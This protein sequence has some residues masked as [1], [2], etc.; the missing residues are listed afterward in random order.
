ML[1]NNTL[2][3][4]VTAHSTVIGELYECICG[5][6]HGLLSHLYEDVPAIVL[7]NPSQDGIVVRHYGQYVGSCGE[8]TRDGDVE[9]GLDYVELLVH[10]R[11]VFVPDARKDTN[12]VL[13]RASLVY[14][15][16][17]DRTR[18]FSGIFKSL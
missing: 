2:M 6:I 9:R 7:G 11:V 17:S 3:R 8:G 1:E 10:S 13:A 12:D 16:V 15:G 14:Y 18:S 5:D 4:I